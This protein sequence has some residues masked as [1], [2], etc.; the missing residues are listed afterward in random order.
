M[1]L[2]HESIR[3]ILYPPEHVFVRILHYTHGKSAMNGAPELSANVDPRM[4]L[5][6]G[7]RSRPYCL[8]AYSVSRFIGFIVLCFSDDKV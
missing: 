2:I 4:L 7:L 1:S 8:F 5:S 3:D 6:L